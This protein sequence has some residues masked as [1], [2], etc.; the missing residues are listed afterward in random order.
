MSSEIL[1]NMCRSPLGRKLL[2]DDD[3]LSHLKHAHEAVRRCR[4]DIFMCCTE[5]AIEALESPLS[6]MRPEDESPSFPSARVM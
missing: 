5:R 3:A 2:V 6:M 1:L 4:D